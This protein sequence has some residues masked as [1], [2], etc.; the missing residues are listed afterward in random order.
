MR[1][2]SWLVLVAIIA[3]G[4]SARADL[5]VIE[6][7]VSTAVNDQILPAVFGGRIVWEDY[8]N[9]AAAGADLWWYDIQAGQSY[10]LVEAPE[11]Q[12]APFI[13]DDL[14]VF[15]DNRDTTSG[16]PYL[17]DVWMVQIGGTASALT[18]TIQQ[19]ESSCLYPGRAVFARDAGNGNWNIIEKNLETLTETPIGATLGAEMYPSTAGKYTVFSRLS[20][21]QYDLWAYDRV[22]ASVFPVCQASGDQWLASTDGRRVVW[23]DWRNAETAPD[24]YM[25]DF[26]TQQET[27]I[28][29]Q[30]GKQQDPVISGSYIVWSDGRSGQWRVQ[31]HDLNTGLDQAISGVTPA[32]LDPRIH[33]NVVVWRDRRNG[34]DD[35]YMAQ[36][37]PSYSPFATIGQVRLSPDETGVELS[38]KIVTRDLGNSFGIQE[39]DRSAGILV[40]GVWA[41]APGDSVSVKGILKTL[42]SGERILEPVI[43]RVASAGDAPVPLG[44]NNR[45]LGGEDFGDFTTGLSSGLDGWGL[46]NVGNLMRVWGRVTA[47]GNG[48]FALAGWNPSAGDLRVEC[49]GLT[50]PAVDAMV[51]VTGIAGLNLSGETRNRLIRAARAEDIVPLDQ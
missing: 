8:R 36:V 10:P 45:T 17:F 26:L 18:R 23:E 40:K 39:P 25:Y 16:G 31:L 12:I 2:C 5:A 6:S 47:S 37:G 9:E 44:V 51:Q 14:V 7:P 22:T 32:A 29:T 13:W 38:G 3:C 49:P 48:W 30:P 41:V 28:C 35:V 34:D 27:A 1:L 46:N 50:A 43:V 15:E 21:T 20:G 24:I 19:E 33:E 42:E 11:D 4:A